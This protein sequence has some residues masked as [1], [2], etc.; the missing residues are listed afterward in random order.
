MHL[1]PRLDKILVMF[2][3]IQFYQHFFFTVFFSERLL[4]KTSYSFPSP[5][6]LLSIFSF[7][8]SNSHSFS[9]LGNEN[10]FYAF[11][12]IVFFFPYPILLLWFFLVIQKLG[13]VVVPKKKK[14]CLS[15]REANSHLNITFSVAFS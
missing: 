13:F 6:S 12:F 7:F 1:T 11:S 4:I 9:R 10:S 15:E 2:V 3:Y 5:L 8:L 14:K